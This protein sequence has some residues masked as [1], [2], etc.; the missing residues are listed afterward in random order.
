MR[1]AVLL[2]V[3]CATSALAD[4]VLHVGT[5][6]VDPPTLVTLGVQLLVTGDDDHDALH[7]R[8]MVRANEP[9]SSDTQSL[10]SRI[11]PRPRVVKCPSGS[12]QPGTG[13]PSARS[14]ISR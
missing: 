4:D 14:H 2:L 13:T 3:L 5:V 8:T 1:A 6:N 12:W 7:C 10:S 9:R 11:G